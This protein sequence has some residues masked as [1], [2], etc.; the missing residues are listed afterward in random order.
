MPDNKTEN[1]AHVVAIDMGYG[2]QRATY[3]LQSIAYR[4]EIINA[5]NYLD[6]PPKD[7]KIWQDSRKFYEY[8]SR[9]K[10]VPVIGNL[11]FKTYDHYQRVGGFYPRRNQSRPTLQ[12][13]GTLSL[14]A[15]KH[16][17]EHFI[18]SLQPNNLPLVTSFFVPAYMAEE[19][20]YPG[21]IYLLICDTDVARAWVAKDPKKSRIKY[22]APCERVV[23]RL[24]QYG[25]RSDHIFLTG[26]P[27]P[28]ENLGNQDLDVLKKDLLNRLANL[29][30]ERVYYKK[31]QKTI[32]K[33]LGELPTKADHPLTL[34][35]AVG[36][37]GAQKE[38]GLKIISSLKSEILDKK[39]QVNLIAGT[40]SDIADYYRTA[41]EE[42]NMLPE[43]DKGIKI[44]CG[45]DKTK[46]FKIFNENL[47]T[48]DILWTKP[49]E[50]SF[51]CGLGLPLI[52]SEPIGSQ[53]DSNRRWIF[54]VG[55]GTDQEDVRYTNE[56]LFDLIK[57]GWLAEAAL[58]GYFD[59][60]RL[61]TYN[62]EKVI[63]G[64]K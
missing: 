28:K 15:K 7:K 16:W 11:V 63:F 8:I 37:A 3:P 40:H 6:I 17:G 1:Q 59:A 25:V 53:E 36:G 57:S 58:Q 39:I 55:S 14:I 33:E 10:N 45:E 13:L 35:F 42:L 27:L 18:S 48:T 12:L 56:W 52:M 44:I 47:R 5:D 49:S 64:E 30:P 19:F 29:D 50:L 26:F 51:Y 4:H 60:P 38:L 32:N 62:I 24:K 34:A 31:F 41:I 2:H 23:E 54:S 43:L 61:G 9:F 21:D 22:L 46:Y 20:N